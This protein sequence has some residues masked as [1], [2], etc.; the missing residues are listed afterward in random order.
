VNDPG[1]FQEILLDL[2]PFDGAA[3]VE[4]DVDVLA[5]PGDNLKRFLHH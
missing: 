2:C 3:L 4:V 1:F 5:E